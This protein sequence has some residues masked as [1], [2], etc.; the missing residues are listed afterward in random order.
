MAPTITLLRKTLHRGKGQHRVRAIIQVA[1]GT[2][3]AYDAGTGFTVSN[4][5]VVPI[6]INA[7]LP[8]KIVEP[9]AIGY[10]YTCSI[11][12]PR[13]PTIAEFTGF[14]TGFAGTHMILDFAALTIGNYAAPPYKRLYVRAFG[15][16]AVGPA[17]EEAATDAAITGGSFTVELEYTP[18]SGAEA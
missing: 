15:F 3:M 9:S 8:E 4:G 7:V 11:V 1:A 5:P 14:T 17:L 10:G 6:D 2:G 16:V 13:I 18:I 12:E